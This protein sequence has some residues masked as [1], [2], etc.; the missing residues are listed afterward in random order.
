[1]TSDILDDLDKELDELIETKNSE[2]KKDNS[3]VQNVSPADSSQNQKV[4]ESKESDSK[5]VKTEYNPYDP[6]LGAMIGSS[7]ASKPSEIEIN[8]V[9]DLSSK[10]NPVTSSEI[11]LKVAPTTI[12]N[13][14]SESSDI[15]SLDDIPIPSVNEPPKAIE[16]EKKKGFFSRLFGSIKKQQV[17]DIHTEVK[18]ATAFEKISVEDRKEDNALDSLI[19]EHEKMFNVD[20]PIPDKAG[21]VVPVQVQSVPNQNINFDASTKESVALNANQNTAEIKSLNDDISKA[22][23]D[24]DKISSELLSVEEEI[25]SAIVNA[26][27]TETILDKSNS[28]LENVEIPNADKTVEPISV[29]ADQVVETVTPKIEPVKAS[30][31][32]KKLNSAVLKEQVSKYSDL[33]KT[34]PSVNVKEKVSSMKSELDVD[35]KKFDTTDKITSAASQDELK[36]IR[37]ELLNKNKEMMRELNK[38]QTEI[39]RHNE[40]VVKEINRLYDEKQKQFKKERDLLD[41]IIK[42]NQRKIDSH[43]EYIQDSEREHEEIRSKLEGEY[44][45]LKTQLENE[46]KNLKKSLESEY[47]SLKLKLEEEIAVVKSNLEVE[48]AAEKSRLEEEYNQRL[49]ETTRVFEEKE[50]SLIEKEDEINSQILNNSKILDENK[51]LLEKTIPEM[52][53]LE[54]AINENS[55]MKIKIISK[56]QD[57]TQIKDYLRKI[58]SERKA[59]AKEE[60]KLLREEADI[61]KKLDLLV[62]RV[63]KNE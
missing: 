42:Q 40:K 45:F 51:S 38:R 36:N 48:K 37:N 23:S 53:R 63:I 29:K 44:Q 43:Y 13:S 10:T 46:N 12:P 50:Q 39:K 11:D 2:K 32:D 7:T 1:M 17:E 30:N 62:E 5:E 28:K 19:K 6:N 31:Q 52:Q 59:L 16:V 33:E 47:Q 3:A 8:K 20:S 26:P 56:T 54:R 15:S 9:D 14:V 55:D 60:E 24:I 4:E 27:A 61:K 41:K 18:K 34:E 22:Q 57:M 58:G 21:D 25:K 49:Y 35:V